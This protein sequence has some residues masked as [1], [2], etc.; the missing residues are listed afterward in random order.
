[1]TA[2]FAAPFS[3]SASLGEADAHNSIKAMGRHIV[4]KTRKAI[5]F[6]SRIMNAFCSFCKR[7]ADAQGHRR[8]Q[9]SLEWTVVRQPVACPCNRQLSGESTLIGGRT[10]HNRQAVA[11]RS[12]SLQKS[13]GF[14]I[15][16]RRLRRVERGNIHAIARAR[17]SASSGNQPTWRSKMC[18][19]IAPELYGTRSPS[20]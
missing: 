10:A 16:D 19:T 9:L 7:Q 3:G 11:M 8:A 12:G 17:A 2:S 4:P 1:M 20:S 18:N 15:K 14:P 13:V 6:V 5:S